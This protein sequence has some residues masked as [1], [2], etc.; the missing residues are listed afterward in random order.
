M[1]LNIKTLAVATAISAGALL[2]MPV[3]SQAMP[4]SSPVK[5][6]AVKNSN[7]VDVRHR[8]WHRR[9]AR[10]CRYNWD[11]PRCYSR[12]H[13]RV[14]RYHYYDEPYYGYYRPYYRNRGPGIGLH[15]DID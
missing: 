3:A 7:I 14:Y 6:D 9:M 12:R 11:D 8:K 15:F 1:L 10:Y 2:A 4:Q 13:S 5:I